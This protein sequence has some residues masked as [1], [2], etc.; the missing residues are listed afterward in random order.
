MVGRLRSAA[1]LS[2]TLV[3]FAHLWLVV[4]ADAERPAARAKKGAEQADAGPDLARLRKKVENQF[5]IKGRGEFYVVVVV[6]T[7]FHTNVMRLVP[8][9]MVQR[10]RAYA[11]VATEVRD[12]GKYYPVRTAEFRVVKGREAAIQFLVDELVKPIEEPEMQIDRRRPAKQARPPSVRDWKPVGRFLD[13]AS[14]DKAAEEAR[15]AFEVQPQWR[16][17]S[18]APAGA[19]KRVRP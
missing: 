19:G 12:D 7:S 4:R 15:L 13:Q 6:T 1:L 17:V 16:P 8:E 5:R 14:A 18:G 9:R 3:P 10:G 2:L 11:G